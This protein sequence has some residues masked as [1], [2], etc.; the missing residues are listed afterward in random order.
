MKAAD[1][2]DQVVL[3]YAHGAPSFLLDLAEIGGVDCRRDGS[4]DADHDAGAA[5][6][7]HVVGVIV[8]S[9]RLPVIGDGVQDLHPVALLQGRRR[10]AGRNLDLLGRRESRSGS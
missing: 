10:G 6:L 9:E 1:K 8:G 4:A 2:L 5:D 7:D 3:F